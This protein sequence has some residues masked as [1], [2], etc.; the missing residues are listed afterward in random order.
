MSQSGTALTTRASYT[1]SDRRFDT[2]CKLVPRHPKALSVVAKLETTEC[3]G[4]AR[5]HS[6]LGFS[7][8]IKYSKTAR[9]A[10]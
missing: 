1:L 6:V 5:T 9:M 10:G 4:A 7:L 2:K 8:L 3:F